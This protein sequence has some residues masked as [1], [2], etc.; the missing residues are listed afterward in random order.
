[1]LLVVSVFVFLMVVS[2]VL[3]LVLVALVM[4]LVALVVTLVVVLVVH[5]FQQLKDVSQKKKETE[6]GS[7]SDHPRV[8]I[9]LEELPEQSQSWKNEAEESDYSF[10]LMGCD[11]G[12]YFDEFRS[13]M[14]NE[15]IDELFKK[16]YFAYF[17]ELPKDCTLRF[18]MR[19][20]YDLIKHTIK[21]AGDDKDLKKVKKIW[22]KSGSTTVACRFVLG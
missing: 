14:E 2:V 19:M 20:V 16:S 7:T 9:N 22:M 1:M 5:L 17:L 11:L 6:S 12:K 18:P 10:S 13:I 8:Q 21:Y 4:V 3:V 15:N